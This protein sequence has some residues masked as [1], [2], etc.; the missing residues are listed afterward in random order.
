[1]RADHDRRAKEAADRV[2]PVAGGARAGLVVD[3]AGLQQRAGERLLV[4]QV[5][6]RAWLDSA[7]GPAAEAVGAADAEPAGVPAGGVEMGEGGASDDQ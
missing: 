5:A 7:D 1:V 4:R 3:R 6:R 2:R